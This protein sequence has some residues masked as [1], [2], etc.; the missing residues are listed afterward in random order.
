MANK[1]GRKRIV[2]DP[3]EI[4]QLAAQGL[5]EAQI[6]A[7]LGINWKT[8]Q[9]RKLQ[10]T[11]FSEALARGK[12]KGINAVTNAL[13]NSA[14]TGN[15]HAQKF[16]LTNRDPESW[17]DKQTVDQNTTGTVTITIDESMKDVF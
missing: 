16:Y 17:K 5:N 3:E 14:V 9:D 10:F 12:A 8:L 15:F 2:L 4:E 7:N 11:E 13:F 1:G 6:A